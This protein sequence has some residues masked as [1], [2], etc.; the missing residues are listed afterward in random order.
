MF[1]DC[2]L[3]L[4]KI[5]KMV[6]RVRMHGRYTQKNIHREQD[7]HECTYLDAHIHNTHLCAA[8]GKERPHDAEDDIGSCCYTHAHAQRTGRFLRM[9]AESECTNHRLWPLHAQRKSIMKASASFS[10]AIATQLSN[11]ILRI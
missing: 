1:G 6:A 5:T 3:H 7:V 8:V 11:S 2:A 10:P 9:C 4:K